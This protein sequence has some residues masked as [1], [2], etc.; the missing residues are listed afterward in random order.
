M[1]KIW[2]PSCYATS[3]SFSLSITDSC[4]KRLGEDDRISTWKFRENDEI[5]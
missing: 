5:E 2:P 4:E 3:I 1:V